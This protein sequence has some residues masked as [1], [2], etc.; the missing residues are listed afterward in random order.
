MR[1]GIVYVS[2]PANSTAEHTGRIIEHAELRALLA[3]QPYVE[4]ELMPLIPEL[5]N[6]LSQALNA[7][8]RSRKFPTLRFVITVRALPFSA[9]CAIIFI[10]RC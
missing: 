6:P 1:A 2:I 5:D 10:S 7:I 8:L 4:K 3:A 9:I